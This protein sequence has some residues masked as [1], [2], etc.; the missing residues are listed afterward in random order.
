MDLTKSFRDVFNWRN[1]DKSRKDSPE[2]CRRDMT[3]NEKYL[4]LLMDELRSQN[5]TFTGAVKLVKAIFMAQSQAE[6][7]SAKTNFKYN[8]YRWDYGPFDSAIYRDIEKLFKKGLLR[9]STHYT[10]YPE[11]TFSLT[12]DGEREATKIKSQVDQTFLSAIEHWA[13]KINEMNRDAV[14]KLVYEKSKVKDYEMG[15]KI[16]LPHV[17]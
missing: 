4:L 5:K 16:A 17:D 6:T 14:L 12:E 3:M 11:K 1:V 7:K 8:F 10:P 2:D 13:N 9:V 15:D